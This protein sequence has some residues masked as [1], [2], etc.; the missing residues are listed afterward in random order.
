[1]NA[2]KKLNKVKNYKSFYSIE[3]LKEQISL[4]NNFIDFKGKLKKEK[5]KVSV[6]AEMKKASPSAGTIVEKYNPIEIGKNCPP[7]YS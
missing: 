3:K 1:M 7:V 2:L 6:I 5:S 4:Y